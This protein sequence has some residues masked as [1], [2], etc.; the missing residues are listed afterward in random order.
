[1]ASLGSVQHPDLYYVPPARHAK[2][3]AFKLPFSGYIHFIGTHIHPYA[4][5][6]ILSNASIGQ[7]LWKGSPQL[8]PRGVIQSMQ[9]YSCAER[10]PIRARVRG[11]RSVT[12]FAGDAELR[13]GRIHG[14]RRDRLRAERRVKGGLA[15]GRVTRDADRIPR[16]CF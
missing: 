14:L 8:G 16:A 4:E 13:G 6:V 9:T 10:I 7:T 3:A 11:A 15:R 2:T 1:M 5:S 12:G